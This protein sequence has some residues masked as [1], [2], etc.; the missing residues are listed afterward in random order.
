MSNWDDEDFKPPAPIAIVAGAFEG[1]DLD[2]VKDN[3][4]DEDDEEKKPPTEVK[5]DKSQKKQKDKSDK[6]IV[7]N[8]EIGSPQPE[9]LTPEQIRAL[10]QESELKMFKELTFGLKEDSTAVAQDILKSDEDVPK[11]VELFAN[12]IRRTKSSKHIELYRKML[13][14]LIGNLCLDDDL[15]SETLRNI[16]KEISALST[17]KHKL[18][19]EKQKSKQPKKKAQILGT[20]KDD[21]FDLDEHLTGAAFDD[22]D[23]FM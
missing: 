17:E 12:M 1:E 8:G 10:Q 2:F 19:K 9:D 13:S 21:L 22:D 11:V 23:E 6:K 18:E 14:S 5:K 20:K 3:W 4:E 15:E 16:S 7:E